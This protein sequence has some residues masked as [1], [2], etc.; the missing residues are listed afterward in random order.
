MRILIGIVIGGSLAMIFPEYAAAGFEY[1]RD[2]VN[3]FAQLIV[4]KTG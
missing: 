4:E 2:H 3:A 1:I